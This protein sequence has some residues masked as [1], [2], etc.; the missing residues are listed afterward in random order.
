MSKCVIKDIKSIIINGKEYPYKPYEFLITPEAIRG[1]M[2]T[3]KSDNKQLF[4]NK[5]DERVE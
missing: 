2:G 5:E 1:G 3:Y 4:K